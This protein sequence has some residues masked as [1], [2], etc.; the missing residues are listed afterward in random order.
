MKNTNILEL[1]MIVRNSGEVLR[2]CLR[3]NKAF[4]DHWTVLDTGS[5]DNTPDI[6]RE[7]LKDVPGNLYFGEFIDFSQARNKSL[8]L[9]SK[10]CKYTLILDDS[11]V[12]HGG[13]ELRNILQSGKASCYIIKIGKYIDGFLRDDYFSKRIIKS[14]D[15]LR[16][17]YRVH[18]DIVVNDYK[19]R[20]ISD[21][22]IFIDDL[23]FAEHNKR[24]TNRYKKDII[25]L[26]LD[27]KDHPNNPR[28]VYYIA[29][30]YY[31][32]EYPVK[33]LEFYNI[34]KNIRDIK[35][36]FLFSAYY[37]STCIDFQQD[38]DVE[39]FKSKLVFIEKI[40]KNRVEP[41]YK[42]AV[43]H[44]ESGDFAKVNEIVSRLI[45]ISKPILVET[46]IEHDIY[47]YYIPYLYIESNIIL[48]NIDKAVNVLKRLLTLYPN[49]QPLLNIKYSISVNPT[50]SSI[51]LSEN[52]TIVFH[53][54]TPTVLHCWNPKGDTRISGS[55]HM[56]LNLGKEFQK[57]GFRVIIIGFF[58]DTEKNINYE[59][60]HGGIEY[61]DY[62]YFSEFC[63][64]YVVDILIVSRFTS[65]LVYY[66][67]IKSV[68]LWI[69]DILPAN[70]MVSRFIQYHREKFKGIIAISE[71][72]KM[73]TYKKLNVPLDN[74]IVSRNAIYMDR[75]TNRDVLKTPYRF[76]YSSCPE[77]GLTYLV[78]LI[79][80]IKKRYPETTLYIF[81]RR[82]LI[83][84]E[85]L[86]LIEQLDYI[87]LSDRVSQDELA[88]EF[89]K[90]DIW[91]YPTDFQEAYCITALE[92]MA[93]K[94]LVTTVDYCGLGNIVHGKGIVCK[95]PI[96]DNLDDILN[97]LF[98]VMDRPNLKEHFINTAF[99]WASKQTYENLYS[100]WISIFQKN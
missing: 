19:I 12:L 66:D 51:Q 46:L 100:D 76:I 77:R 23:T 63:L 10:K 71:W 33:S 68:Y 80:K 62:K 36:D 53:T 78:Q 38:D 57:M 87:F 24:S 6:I 56:A 41:S 82:K 50:I 40:F 49:D 13:K 91:L 81:A 2:T 44:K 16:Y 45:T 94:C 98:F 37:D 14:S 18:E 31:E 73:N 75:F 17:Q 11:Y 64:K 97:K 25:S 47:D 21:S 86:A 58:N 70:E 90:S 3:T 59:G 22:K 69:H 4:I 88:I 72:Q 67:N 60:E 15:N 54:G 20:S 26:L 95:P 89:L 32:L 43:L 5:T 52:K 35:D 74:I 1:V 99:T 92:A 85:T 27:Y 55:E 9:S 7:E 79:P 93:A 42:L 83:D 34:L 48:G 30:T 39:K 84:N 8:E 29:K 65:N 61:I 28:I 96:E